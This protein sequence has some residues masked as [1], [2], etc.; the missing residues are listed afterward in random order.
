MDNNSI[1]LLRI[2][3]VLL[4]FCLNFFSLLSSLVRKNFGV[5]NHSISYL[6]SLIAINSFLSFWLSYLITSFLYET[7]LPKISVRIHCNV[8]QS[9]PLLLS[10][11]LLIV[12]LFQ[13]IYETFASHRAKILCLL[14]FY[15]WL[16]P[17]TSYTLFTEINSTKDFDFLLLNGLMWPTK[18]IQSMMRNESRKIFDQGGD[19]NV[20]ANILFCVDRIDSFNVRRMIWHYITIVV[21]ITS[22]YIICTG[23]KWFSETLPA[24]KR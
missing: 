9:L 14:I 4:F 12:F 24:G 20:N 18:S 22:I 5:C 15:L 2:C 21:P 10:T 19:R 23:A 17:Q 7:S 3:F 1:W 16:L 6:I 11:I 8:Q 13:R